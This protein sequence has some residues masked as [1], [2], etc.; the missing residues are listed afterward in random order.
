MPKEEPEGRPSPEERKRARCAKKV[1]STVDKNYRT[2][3]AKKIKEVIKKLEEEDPEIM[4]KILDD[5]ARAKPPKKVEGGKESTPANHA[6][7]Q[8]SSRLTFWKANPLPVQCPIC[9]KMIEEN[10]KHGLA[11]SIDHLR[12]WATIKTEIPT[13]V[14]CK[15]GVHWSVVL[16][17]SMRSVFQEKKNLRPLHQGCNSG[18]NG[19]KDTDSIAP[20]RLG[21]CP[22][23]EIC[24]ELKGS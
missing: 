12:P 16:A 6:R 9:K 1:L 22:G 8:Q 24:K 13:V 23:E 18:K 20:Q 19:P 21:L 14:V 10:G 4:Q 17:E 3:K 11:P 15:D 2:R 7:L 5:A